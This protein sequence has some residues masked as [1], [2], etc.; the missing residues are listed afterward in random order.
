M[1]Q[2]IYEGVDR[3]RK[4]GIQIT[5]GKPDPISLSLG[6]M[7]SKVHVVK[8]DGKS[9]K[10]TNYTTDGKNTKSVSGLITKELNKQF[11]RD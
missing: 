10:A 3:V 8:Y 11:G 2:S 7:S 9:S 1:A 4:S 6:K 5:A